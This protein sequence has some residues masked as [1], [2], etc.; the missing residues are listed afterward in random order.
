MLPFPYDNING[1]QHYDWFGSILYDAPIYEV[2]GYTLVLE[3]C[4]MIVVYSR[5]D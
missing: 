4:T 3:F 2:H 1:N 5:A